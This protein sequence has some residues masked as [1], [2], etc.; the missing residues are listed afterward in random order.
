MTRA[1]AAYGL[2]TWSGFLVPHSEREHLSLVDV[3]DAALEVG[4]ADHHLRFLQ[5]P[6]GLAMG[7]GAGLASQLGPDGHSTGILDEPARHRD[8]GA[9]ECAALRRSP[10]RPRPEGDPRGLPRGVERCASVS[11]VRAQHARC[12]SSTVVG[13]REP[14]H[15]DDNLALARVPPAA[16]ATDR[17]ALP[18]PG[19]RVRHARPAR[20]WRTLSSHEPEA[21]LAPSRDESS[22][23]AG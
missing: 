2:C 15:V 6:Y 4:S 14:E 20:T 7:E 9:R 11:A 8:F 17:R 10:G 19:A 13:M 12:I 18:P 16:A 5:L 23:S 3:F 1:I 21:S 22:R